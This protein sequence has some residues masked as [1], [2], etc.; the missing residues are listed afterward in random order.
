[1]PSYYIERQ[2]RITEKLRPLGLRRRTR[3]DTEPLGAL[4]EGKTIELFIAE[5]EKVGTATVKDGKIKVHPEGDVVVDIG[6]TIGFKQTVVLDG[7]EEPLW[8]GS[9]TTSGD[10]TVRREDG[11]RAIAIRRAPKGGANA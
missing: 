11:S 2:T 4:K 3:V 5:D 1:M 10:V 6:N 9:F 7:K 8:V